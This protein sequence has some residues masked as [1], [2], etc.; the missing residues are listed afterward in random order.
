MIVMGM[1]ISTAYCRLRSR[2]VLIV[3]WLKLNSV[4][5]LVV[6]FALPEI[7]QVM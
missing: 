5:T 4:V 2:I 6:L 1:Y 7:C 3:Q